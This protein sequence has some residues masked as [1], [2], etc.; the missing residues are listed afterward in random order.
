MLTAK[1]TCLTSDVILHTCSI[2]T[3]Y[4]INKKSGMAL[5]E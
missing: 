1:N 4:Q 2:K 3:P 5:S